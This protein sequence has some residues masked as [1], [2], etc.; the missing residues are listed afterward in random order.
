[1]REEVEASC[2]SVLDVPCR[3]KEEG[4]RRFHGKVRATLGTGAKALSQAESSGKF[5]TLA[6]LLALSTEISRSAFTS[7][8]TFA[9]IT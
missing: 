4:G 5:I 1:M 8:P 3:R 2:D 7:I 6:L 9:L